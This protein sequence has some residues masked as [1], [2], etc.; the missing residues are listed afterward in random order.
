[1]QAS[2]FTSTCKSL[3]PLQIGTKIFK[4]SIGDPLY[5]KDYELVDHSRETSATGRLFHYL[6]NQLRISSTWAHS[7][8]CLQSGQDR[9]PA[10]IGEGRKKIGGAE[11]VHVCTCTHP[12]RWE[13]LRGKGK[14]PGGGGAVRVGPGRDREGVEQNRA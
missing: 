12:R 11:L 14:G 8:S 13:S 3:F 10:L 1:M 7:W 2:R 5:L 4:R 6:C 9:M